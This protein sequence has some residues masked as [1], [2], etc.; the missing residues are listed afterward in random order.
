MTPS[1]LWDAYKAVLRGKIIA[2]TSLIKKQKKE[3]LGNYNGISRNY[4]ENTKIP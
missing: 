3:K 1:V 4:R 2:L